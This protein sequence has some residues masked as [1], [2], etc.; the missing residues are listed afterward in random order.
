ME[1]I[2][3]G[4]HKYTPAQKTLLERAGL[5]EEV[6]R[7]QHVDNPTEVTSRAKELG[8]AIVIQ[9]LPIPVLASLLQAAKRAGVQVYG[10]RLKPVGLFK[11]RD[12]AVVSG[13]DVIVPSREGTF[14]V[15]KTSALQ[16]LIKVE[17]VAEDVVSI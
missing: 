11:S 7:I 5:T 16:R 1:Y 8:A 6:G 9:A 2:T 15:M 3:V 14:R 10:F 12:E 17:I 4:R 13:G